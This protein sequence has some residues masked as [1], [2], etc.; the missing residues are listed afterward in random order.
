ME[1]L[2]LL[3]IELEGVSQERPLIIAG[4]CSAETEEQVMT[5][6]KSLSD[7]GIKIFRAGIWKPRTK[8]GGFEGIGVEGLSWLKEVKKETGMY[9]AT[10]VATAKHVYECLKA[11]VDIVWIGARTT[12]NPFAVQEIA[13]AL[14]GVDIPVYVK[15]PVNPDLELWIG[16]LER[17]NNA[18]L[19]VSV[20]FIADSL[21]T[22]RKFTATCRSGI[23]LS[24]CAAASR[25]C[26]L[27][28]TRAISAENVN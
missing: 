26:L 28:A 21:H 22:T 27:S 1:Q 4:P 12:A 7:K 8:P 10:E 9:V 5:T 14:K 16:A 20:P 18:G 2:D 6:A 17:I 24:N 13:D 23:F 3:P 15:N 25:T 11:D 19:N